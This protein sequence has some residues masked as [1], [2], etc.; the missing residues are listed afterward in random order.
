[1]YT[2]VSDMFPKESVAS[3]VG[4]GTMFGALAA[5]GFADLTG[6]VLEQTGEYWS[7]FAIAGLAYLVALGVIQFLLPQIVPVE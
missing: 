7:L 2:L 3:V 5:I 4:L 6:R 1:M